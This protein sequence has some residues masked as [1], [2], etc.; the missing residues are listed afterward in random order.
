MT[1]TPTFDRSEII[2]AMN[3]YHKPGDV[4]ELRIP[5][6]GR[7]KTI[8]GYFNDFE[9]LADSVVGLSDDRDVKEAGGVYITLNQI[10][11]RL[12]SRSNN[13]Y[14]KYSET[15]TSDGDVAQLNWLPIDCDPIRPVGIPSSNE[16]HEAALAMVREI[17]A[18]L[19]GRGWP[20]GAFVVGDS[21]NGGHLP[22]KID[23]EPSKD[24]VDLV[25][26]CLAALDFIFSDEGVKVDLTTFNPARIWKLPGTVTRKGD[27]SE[28]RPHR[29][30]RMLEVPEV[31]ETVARDLLEDL[32]AI[33]P[34]DEPV[35]STRSGDEFDPVRWAKD[36]GLKVSKVKPWS[37]GV[38]A[39]LEVCPF[40]SD[41]KRTARIGRLP[42]GARYFGCFHDGCK[43]ND[44]HSLIDLLDPNR[45]ERTAPKSE[46]SK[47]T[48]EDE[49]SGKKL[50]QA[51]RI[52]DLAVESGAEFWLSEE[53]EA[54]ISIPEP[55]HI[56][57]HPLKSS[58]VQ[59]WLSGLLFKAAATTPNGQSVRDAL[60]VLDGIARFGGEVH[61]VFVRLAGHK[62][63]IYLD[64][65]GPN[66]RAV[67]I[68]PDGWRVI[69]SES[70][71]VKFRRSKGMLEI[72][73]PE[74]GG[75][76]EDLRGVLN[77]P[78][79][80]PWILARAWLI[81][82]FNPQGPYPIGIVNGEQG[83]GKSW[84]GRILRYVIDPNVSA[85]RRPPRSERDLMIAAVNSWVIAYDNL[86]GLP[87]WLGDAICTLS[88]GGGL[89]QRELYSDREESLLDAQRPVI[90]NGIDTI[91]TR[92]DLLDRA[93]IFNLPRID[94][95]KRRT[96]KKIIA[97]LDRIRP[98]VI[99]AILDIVSH[100]L[101]E[102]PR[103]KLDQLPRLADFAEWITACEGALRWEPGEFLRAY[104]E[105][106]DDANAT[107]IDNDLF[108][109]SLVNFIKAGVEPFE[110]PAGFLLSALEERAGVD[111]RYPPNG[112]PRTPQG[113]S[114]KLKRITPALRA[115]GV[116]VG[117][118]QRTKKS[119][120]I[121][122]KWFPIKSTDEKGGK[123][124]KGDVSRIDTSPKKPPS[125]DDGDVGDVYFSKLKVGE[126][127]ERKR[128]ENA[129]YKVGEMNVTNVTSSPDTEKKVTMGDKGDNPTISE[130]LEE[131]CQREAEHLEKFK[132]PE[133]TP[134]TYLALRDIPTFTDG[135]KSWTLERDDVF[136]G[137][138]DKIAKALIGKEAIREVRA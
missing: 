60:S 111:T 104:D 127:R 20:A 117:P 97:E 118:Q 59:S 137:L 35:R 124:D 73:E 119:R 36:H 22:V 8:S 131:A 56:E 57:V 80:D 135:A 27:T 77:V 17:R 49:T 33:L 32:A 103:V 30:A 9:I 130:N 98:G 15:T 105:N 21:G 88:T 24:N 26:R 72:P 115:V 101:S 70:V 40:N 50:S 93:I 125:G 87:P 7:A 16:E 78:E 113:V 41:H 121:R 129:H 18:W 48:T 47:A 28:E 37:G 110:G 2:R 107:L 64:L 133:P 136:S 92:G 44:W 31:L 138:P 71:P 6:A 90:L 76:L 63:R 4:V 10:D 91:S 58:H 38:L 86:S 126:K 45:R 82:A 83:S 5:K 96:E 81:Q 74:R 89:S 122:I 94:P 79:G 99:G 132:T 39:E 42:S 14:R 114:N 43:G 34:K 1:S 84:F 23:L 3:I 95:D 55:N 13:R 46:T 106:R 75:D 51:T 11:G 52:V 120:N 68:G 109:T 112:W 61:P 134:K 62:G 100:G 128:G 116:E 66:W 108:A 102:L 25:K 67:E 85:L 29:M 19:I 54:F 53:G 65:G 123:G 12:L 69:P